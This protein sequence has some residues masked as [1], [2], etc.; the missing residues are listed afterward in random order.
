KDI[1]EQNLK[2]KVLTREKVNDL[3]MMGLKEVT[4][5]VAEIE[6]SSKPVKTK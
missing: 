5:K 6:K 3:G 2:F 4:A 1:I